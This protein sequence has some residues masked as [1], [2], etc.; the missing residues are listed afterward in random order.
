MKNNDLIINYGGV[1]L[2]VDEQSIGGF[3]TSTLWNFGKEE[4]QGKGRSLDLSVPAT[5]NNRKTLNF[6]DTIPADGVRRGLE[7]SVIC[8]GVAI[9][10][11]RKS[12]V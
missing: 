12:V 6:Y 9:D 8:G 7:G 1:L 2:D 11:D 10:G 3:D 5:T 4:A